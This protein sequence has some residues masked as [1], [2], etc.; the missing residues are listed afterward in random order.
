VGV[1]PRTENAE[2]HQLL[3]YRLR[4]AIE[5]AAVDNGSRVAF[6]L[7]LQSEPAAGAGSPDQWAEVLD[8]DAAAASSEAGREAMKEPW[9]KQSPRCARTQASVDP[10]Q[11]SRRPVQWWLMQLLARPRRRHH[12]RLEQRMGIQ[13]SVSFLHRRGVCESS[14][15]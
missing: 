12:A 10:C 1:A 6:S 5:H 4:A 7:Y 11:A 15:V 9:R 14:R 2:G 8:A 13:R 3:P